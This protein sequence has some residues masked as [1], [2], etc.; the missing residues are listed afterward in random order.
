MAD[1]TPAR[2][3][4]RVVRVRLWLVNL[5]ETLYNFLLRQA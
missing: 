3:P 4:P 5:V 1:P 2:K